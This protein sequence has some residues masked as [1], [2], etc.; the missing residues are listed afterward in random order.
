MKR[1][2]GEKLRPAQGVEAGTFRRLESLDA[3]DSLGVIGSRVGVRSQIGQA[4]RHDGEVVE[5]DERQR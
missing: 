3:L 4:G 2:V 1:P 5:A